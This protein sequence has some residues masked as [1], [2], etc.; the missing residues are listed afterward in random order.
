M[1]LAKSFAQLNI[2]TRSYVSLRTLHPKKFTSILSNV[3]AKP[4]SAWQIFLRENISDLKNSNEKVDIRS[5][6]KELSAKWKALG[7]GE[8]QIYQQ[9]FQQESKAHL[10][11]YHAA[12]NNAS[13]EE[14]RRENVLRKKYKLNL[15]KDPR[16]PKRP[17]SAFLY[18]IEHL[19]AT[20]DPLIKDAR[21]STQ[22]VEAAKRF[23]QLSE[24]EAKVFRDKAEAAKQQYRIDNEKFLNASNA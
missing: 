22:A 20:N 5:V 6:T 8:K 13:S 3:P 12:I 16:Q 7:D 23:R 21:V 19:R 17:M 2:Q 15:L 4:R 14:L 24:S 18:F 11:A 9:K 10:D 1:S